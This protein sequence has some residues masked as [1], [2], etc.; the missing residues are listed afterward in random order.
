MSLKSQ[1][2]SIESP[3]IA[4]TE[5]SRTF[6]SNPSWNLELVQAHFLCP[7]AL[8]KKT[9]VTSCILLGL[10]GDTRWCNAQQY[11]MCS[12]FCF[13]GL[14]S[15]FIKVHQTKMDDKNGMAATKKTT[16]IALLLRLLH[17]YYMID[18]PRNGMPMM[19]EFNQ[20]ITTGQ[21]LA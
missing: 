6:E 11:N 5:H 18:A 20:S 2:L 16:R 21:S 4:F 15:I 12:R 13:D 7:S 14:R 3:H 17:P 1:P 9:R 8:V 19:N 10:R